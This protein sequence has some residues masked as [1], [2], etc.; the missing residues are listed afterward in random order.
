MGRRPSNAPKAEH[1]V[2]WKAPGRLF[3]RS[4]EIATFEHRDGGEPL[5]L[6][7]EIDQYPQSAGEYPGWLQQ[8]DGGELGKHWRFEPMYE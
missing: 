7:P 2:G 1:P 8:M 6:L 3:V 5:I 4:S